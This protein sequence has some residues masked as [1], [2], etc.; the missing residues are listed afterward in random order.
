MRTQ[1]C[2]LLFGLGSSASGTSFSTFLRN[3][4]ELDRLNKHSVP[5]LSETYEIVPGIGKVTLGRVLGRGTASV[6][7]EVQEYAEIA[8]KYQANCHKTDP[9]HPL[10]RQMFY[11]SKAFEVG[12]APE[13]LFVSP[14]QSL[15]VHI[16]DKTNFKG[17]KKYIRECQKVDGSVRYLI[18]ERVTSCLATHSGKARGS[19]RR[20]TK[21]GSWLISM[22]YE[23]HVEAQLIHGQVHS[24]HVCLVPVAGSMGSRP[25]LI[26]FERSFHVSRERDQTT[27]YQ[28]FHPSLSPWQMM[29]YSTTRRDDVFNALFV[30]ADTMS[31]RAAWNYAQSLID[32]NRGKE[33]IDWKFRGDFWAYADGWNRRIDRESTRN[34]GAILDRLKRISNLLHSTVSTARIDYYSIGVELNSAFKRLHDA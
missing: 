26:D 34:M 22:L 6:I 13:H 30:V 5:R 23:L 1:L 21:L 8:I 29:G 24:G 17:G 28:S 19:A 2:F 18:I 7:F 12:V 33:L 32:A 15:P 20:A 31:Q 3:Q 16:T 9:V 27:G 11:G 14:A 4:I 10:L 25:V